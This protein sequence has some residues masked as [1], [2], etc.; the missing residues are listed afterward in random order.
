M[1]V[2]WDWASTTHD[3]TVIDDAGNIVDRWA[4]EHTETGLDQT[5]ARLAGYGRPE[6]LP[7]AIERP[8]GLVVDR[9]SAAG[10]PIIP[11]H[12]NAF[13]ATRPRWGA[14]AA[15]SDPGDSFK[16]ADYL[17]TD[18]HRLRRLRPLDAATRE[19]P[20]RSSPGSAPRSPWHS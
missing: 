9:L 14:A 7:V 17:R 12:P 1:F 16:L 20:S 11:I 3:V 19:A 5:L 13:H 8:S 4:A 18:G 10:H 6:Q 15:K 2:G